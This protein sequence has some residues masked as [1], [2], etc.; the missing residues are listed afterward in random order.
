MTAV[1][2]GIVLIAFCN[3]KRHCSIASRCSRGLKMQKTEDASEQDRNGQP[4]AVEKSVKR[5]AVGADD[6]LDEIAGAL[7]HPRA[8]MAGSAFTQNPRAHQRR[9]SQGDK[10]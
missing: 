5:A 7:F 2:P 9:Q 3:R 6:A 1:R 4:S 10:T 8:F